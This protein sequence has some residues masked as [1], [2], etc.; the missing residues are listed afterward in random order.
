MDNNVDCLQCAPEPCLIADV[1]DEITH[2][3]I[4]SDAEVLCHF[5]LFEL[6]A[7]E[8]DQTPNL[9]EKLEGLRNERLSE[10]TRPAGDKD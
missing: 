10:R 9:R 3:R 7:R 2:G 1:A 8:D 4:F 5:E 6:I